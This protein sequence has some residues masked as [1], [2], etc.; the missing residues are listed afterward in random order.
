MRCAILDDYQRVALKAADWGPVAGDLEIRVFGAPL[1]DEAAAAAAL[2][3]FE[4]IVAMRERTPF[5]RTLI[6]RLPR[7]RL[8]GHDRRSQR[9]H[10]PRRRR[11]ASSAWARSGVWSPATVGRSP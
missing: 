4:V 3:D 8:P 1:K 5:P 6:E 7:L 10:R 9:R 11:R 2:A